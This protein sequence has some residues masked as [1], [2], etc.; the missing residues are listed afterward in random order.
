MS[1][2]QCHSAGGDCAS[3]LRRAAHRGA[4]VGPSVGLRL[5]HRTMT[6]VPTLTRSNK[7][8]TSAFSMRMQP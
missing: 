2:S 4:V 5:T 8:T 6:G 1:T 7:S 3:R